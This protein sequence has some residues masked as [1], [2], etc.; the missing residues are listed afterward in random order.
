MRDLAIPL[1]GAGGDE[2][3]DRAL[4]GAC[5]AGD[6][7][8]LRGLFQRHA[9][10]VYGVLV[11]TRRID[12]K[13]LDDLVQLTF[14]AV[15]RSARSFDARASVGTWIVAIAMNLMRKYLRNERRRRV[16]MLAVAEL[17]RSVHGK[18]PHDQI[19]RRQD[20]ARLQRRIEALPSRLRI[21][22]TLV[23]LEG[24]SGV[25]VARALELPEGTV[26]SRLHQARERLR[27]SIEEGG[28]PCAAWRGGLRHTK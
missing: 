22:L 5:A 25:E 21:V 12:D 3:S 17:P 18:D 19:A 28:R 4:L 11:R 9:E 24:K 2:R 15:Q 8:A 26:W 7:L 20:L 13:D 10:R 27:Q 14:I 6:N 23:D 16:T 1:R